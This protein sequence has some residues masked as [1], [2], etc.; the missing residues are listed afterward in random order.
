MT[1]YLRNDQN[2]CV[3]TWP[4]TEPQKTIG[5]SATPLKAYSTSEI[6]VDE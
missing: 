6:G 5:V 4:A 2:R 3:V 1:I